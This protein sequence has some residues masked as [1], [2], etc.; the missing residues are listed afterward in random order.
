M[1][2]SQIGPYAPGYKPSG[3]KNPSFCEYCGYEVH[4]G[5]RE[6]PEC[7]GPVRTVKSSYI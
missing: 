5:E 3:A 4:Y 1:K 7:G 6:C 2:A